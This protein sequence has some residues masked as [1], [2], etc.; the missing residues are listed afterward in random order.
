MGIQPM[1]TGEN[2]IRSQKRSL[3]LPRQYM[4][5]EGNKLRFSFYTILTLQD[6]SF[7]KMIFRNKGHD[8]MNP[9]IL[10]H[11]SFHQSGKVLFHKRIP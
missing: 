10:W 4:T 7:Y 2:K 8:H 5:L 1:C 3:A 11:T 6:I 9:Q